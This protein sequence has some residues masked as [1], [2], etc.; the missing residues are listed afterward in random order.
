M[1]S[2][3]NKMVRK[4][5]TY[6]LIVAIGYFIAGQAGLLLAI[7]PSNAAAVWPAAGVAL[8][9]I[10]IHGNKILPGILIGGILVQT[11]SFL[12]ASSTEKIISSVLIGTVIS[13]GAMCQAWIGS[14][15]VQRI[16]KYDVALLRERSIMWFCILAGPVSCVLSA[17]IG[18]FTLWLQGI[19]NFS[20]LPLAWSTWWIG[21]S[22]GVL[23][24]TPIILCLF[25]NPRDLWR[26][27]IYSV[28]IP[29]SILTAVA[30]ITF[31]LSYQKEMQFVEDEF[32]RNTMQFT[33]EL[34]NSINSHIE[35]TKEVK[36]LFDNFDEISEEVFARNIKP[37]VLQNPE[38]QALEWIPVVL[39]KDRKSF[40]ERLGTEIK[41]PDKNGEMTRSPNKEFYYPIQ[42]LEPY[43]GNEN[44][45]GF[46][47]RNNP[48]ALKATEVACSSGEIAVTDAIRLVQE[49][50]EKIG[51]VYYAP[52]YKNIVPV[53][54]NDNC[55]MLSG[56]VASVFRLENE[57]NNIHKKLSELKILVSLKNNSQ[58]FYSDKKED[59]HNIPNQF[60]F[61]RSYEMPVANQQWEV[62]FSPAS[63]FVSLYSSWTIWL[64]II[65]GLL[66]AGLSGIGLLMLTGR[67]LRT[68]DLV[69]LRT[70]ELN[71]EIKERMQAEELLS[72]QAGHDA[73]TGLIN[74]REFERRAE[75][76]LSTI[77]QDKDEH[78]LCFMDL[79][80]FKIVNDTCGHIAGDELLRQL[81]I[82]LQHEVRKR[83]T[84]ARLGGDEFGVLMEHCSLEHAHRVATTLQKAI[85]DFQFTWEG[86][87]FKIGVS[88]GLV[89]I[90]EVVA[91]L[92]ELLK[93]A[94]A[95]CYM[96]KDL[97]RNCIHV[98]Q[99][100]DENMAQRH[101]EMQWVT[102]I[103]KVLKEDRFC[104]Y[105][106]AI[107]PL[108]NS[109]DRHYE[110]LVRMIDEQG[111]IIPPGAFLPAAERYNLI[112][113][114]D[115][116]VIE[117]TFKTLVDNPVFLRQINFISINL[118][119]QSLTKHDFLYF[120][121]SQL[122]SSGL[123]GDKICFE[124]TE[125]A[126]IANL[127]TAI[128]FIATLNELGCR[129]ALDDFGSGLS[130]F[131][132]LKNF[133]V[134]YL[135][136]D[137]MFVRDIVDD[138]IDHAMVKSINDI[139]HVMGMQT[140]AEFVENDEI[141]GMLREIG[142]NYAQGYGIAKPQSIIEIIDDVLKEKT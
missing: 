101:G 44:A 107:A 102:R 88:I 1:E 93:Q 84:L 52:V 4:Y 10:L 97:G 64:I 59:G 71:S 42:Y 136:I 82:V 119:G 32:E 3:N 31:K 35:A 73:L 110:I 77:Q 80:Q 6:N 15:L 22:I 98:Y 45:L 25:G 139:G 7:P 92:T 37:I 99:S 134:D 142:V 72:F 23:I 106:Q 124:I 129:F 95:A 5:L 118:S 131:G 41:I 39:H 111:D 8:A 46:D 76:L 33:S 79:D 90:T 128:K 123:D 14:K 24:F 141:K 12:D 28:V 57:I 19:L 96:A 103:Q 29:L 121:M 89:S 21:D 133:P 36:R 66:I 26:Q 115:R 85:Q 94:D 58:L 135:K 127:S 114:I 38:I 104:L 91:D 63:G 34:N 48:I 113:Q 27:R 49:K 78:A 137:G 55:K 109:Q 68:E 120:I 86:N 30:F 117:N 20:D 83:D 54:N 62:L 56:F 53:E 87:S 11:F 126:A 17:S 100:E 43:V 16:I 13:A 69:E 122:D 108:D 116:W 2:I 47:I 9:A 130:S 18:I 132:Y 75:R 51:V 70:K 74:R 61:K 125:T 50:G 105:A 112:E 40:E 140:I 67:A 60:Q 81:S 65:G 138:P